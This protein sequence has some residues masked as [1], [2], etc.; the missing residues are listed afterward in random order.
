MIQGEP[1]ERRLLCRKCL[2]T[3]TAVWEDVSGRRVLLSLSQG[4]HRRARLPLDLPPQ[5]V[6]D[7]GVPQAEH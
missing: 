7:C 6:C 2:K 5:I 3:G 1:I 4:F